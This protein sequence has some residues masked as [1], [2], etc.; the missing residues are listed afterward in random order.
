MP[1]DTTDHLEAARSL[2]PAA[3]NPWYVLA[4]IHGEQTGKR[5]DRDVH[6]RNRRIWNGWSG[7]HLAASKLGHFVSSLRL[8]PAEFA[9]WTTEERILVESAFL[10]QNLAIPES[11]APVDLRNTNFSALTDFSRFTFFFAGLFSKLRIYWQA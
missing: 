7:G 8:D 10:R 9:P 1:S 5:C 2:K 11:I 3:E 4:T 6:R